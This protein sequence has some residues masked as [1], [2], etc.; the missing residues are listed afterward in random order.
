MQSVV[1]SGK[2]GSKISE[3]QK[4]QIGSEATP[5]SL[6]LDGFG[7]DIF[8]HWTGYCSGKANESLFYG[9]PRCK[10][11]IWFPK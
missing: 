3:E 11:G 9:F 5:L 4:N 6:S 8:L 2:N 1:L 7:H 10:I